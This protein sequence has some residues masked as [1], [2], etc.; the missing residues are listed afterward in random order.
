[1]LSYNSRARVVNVC[2][3]KVNILKNIK[4]C[5]TD[6]LFKPTSKVIKINQFNGEI[7]DL[8]WPKDKEE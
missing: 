2:R 5:N 7:K 4:R 8:K 3:D 1:M 6:I